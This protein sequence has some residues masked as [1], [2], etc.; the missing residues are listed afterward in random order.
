MNLNLFCINYIFNFILLIITLSCK[1]YFT[2]FFGFIVCQSCDNVPNAP[3]CGTDYVTYP[4]H[5]AL[6]KENCKNIH[7]PPL[8][9]LHNGECKPSMILQFRI[10]ASILLL[11]PIKHFIVVCRKLS[12]NMNMKLI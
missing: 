8:T 12:V 9:V 3:V 1:L 7:D 11:L 4:N 6:E 5:C 2:S 10:F